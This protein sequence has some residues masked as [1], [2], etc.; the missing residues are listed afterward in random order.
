M[1]YEEAV[2]TLSGKTILVTGAN[3]F[4]GSVL[5]RT[6]VE[7]GVT[8]RAVARASS[9]R[10][11]LSDLNI[12][13][14]IG[15][16][17]ARET[18]IKACSGIQYLF[19]VAAC[20]RNAKARDED[21]YN[22][23]VTSTMELA[24]ICSTLP[25]FQRFIHISTV[26]VHGHIETPP[27]NENA[28]FAPGDVY[29]R[30]KAEADLWIREYSNTH[31]L[32]CTILRPC[33]IYGPEDKRLLKLFRL[34]RAPI[35]PIFGNGNCLYHLIH[36]EDLV[37]AMIIAA[38]SPSALGETFIV[39]NPEAIKIEDLAR[40]VSETLGRTLRTLRI[41]ITPLFLC[42]DLCEALCK[43]FGISP[44]L[45][46][47]RV[48]F[49]TKDRSFDTTHLQNRLGFTPTLSNHEGIK[50]TTLWYAKHNWL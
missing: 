28:P 40:C 19:H 41:P 3:G 23:H 12:E 4:T 42:A 35:F 45:Y 50:Q 7:N 33:A 26:G 46:R 5:V 48:A 14:I 17:G 2:K 16:I 20:Y 18:L 25:D 43:P 8:V 37:K 10:D 6:L 38:V 24:K 44:P 34:A 21:Y 36:V 47:R 22:V 29:Q 49:Y 32:P 13:W 1:T 39:G 27:A 31:K 30:T 9:N 11:H 15:D